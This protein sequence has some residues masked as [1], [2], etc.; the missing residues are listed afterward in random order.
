MSGR[1]RWRLERPPGW[2]PETAEEFKA[3]RDGC[4]HARA[5]ERQRQRRAAR[6]RVDYYPSE[7]AR[8][9]IVARLRSR[10]HYD[11][12]SVINRL[13]LAGAALEDDRT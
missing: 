11:Q 5:L 8:A 12:S 13:I 10:I 2:E 3:W 7:E 6:P 4:R 1:E 9:V